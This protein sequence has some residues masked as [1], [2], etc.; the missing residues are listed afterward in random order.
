MGNKGVTAH[1]IPV[2]PGGKAFL[3]ILPILLTSSTALV[4]TSL[5]G[6]LGADL[7]YLL[8]F[9]FYWLW[10]VS[11]PLLLFGK[12]G[13]L[14]LFRAEAPLFRRENWFLIALLSLT[15]IGAFVAYFVPNLASVSPWIVLFSPVAI[16]N[17]I[18]EELLWRGTYVKAFRHNALLACIYPALG[19]AISHI[20]PGLVFPAEGGALPFLLSTVFLGLSYGWVAYRTGSAKW[21][22]ITHSLIGLLAFGQPLSTS[23]VRLVFP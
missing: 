22:A 17:G 12:D 23:I 1:Q 13:F 7:G 2:K 21:T 11:V 18:C 10:C 19:F 3:L 14:S 9:G 6:W 5:A 4:F 15:L 16:V 8:G 20:S